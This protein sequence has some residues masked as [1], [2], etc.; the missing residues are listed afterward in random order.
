MSYDRNGHILWSDQP[1]TSTYDSAVGVATDTSGNVY[2]LGNTWG[3][4]PHTARQGGQDAF[5]IK[6]ATVNVQ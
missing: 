2:V 6:Y 3:S 1:G 4:M 5:L